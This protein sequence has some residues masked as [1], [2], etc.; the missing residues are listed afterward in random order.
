MPSSLGKETFFPLKAG[1]YLCLTVRTDQAFRR[2]KLVSEQGRLLWQRAYP[3]DTTRVSLPHHPQGWIS[4]RGD[5]GLRF[6]LIIIYTNGHQERIEPAY[7][8]KIG[9]VLPLA[10]DWLD[11][12]RIAEAAHLLESKGPSIFPGFSLAKVPFSLEGAAG[13]WVL[14]NHPNPPKGFVPYRGPLPQAP[15]P[16]KVYIGYGMTG[17]DSRGWSW[18]V[19]GVP[20]AALKFMPYWWVLERHASP[21]FDVVREPE[22]ND[23]IYVVLHEAFH[24]WW[25]K[26]FSSE[27]ET[28]GSVLQPPA[29][30]AIQKTEQECLSRAIQSAEETGQQWVKA[31]L[32][33]RERRRQAQGLTPAAKAREQLLEMG[34]GLSMYVG[35]KAM[36]AGQAQDYRPLN[37]LYADSEFRGYHIVSQE[38]SILGDQIR[39]GHDMHSSGRAMVQLLE[40][41]VVDWQL[42]VLAGKKAE[43]LLSESAQLVPLPEASQMQALYQAERAIINSLRSP[44]SLQRGDPFSPPA[45]ALKVWLEGL[46][47]DLWRSIQYAQ[48][49]MGKPVS[50]FHGNLPGLALEINA[51][52][53]AEVRPKQV[54]ILWEASRPLAV[55]QTKEGVWLQGE[56]LY[57]G[58]Q[59][60]I[61]WGTDGIHVRYHDDLW[62]LSSSQ[63]VQASKESAILFTSGVLRAWANRKPAKAGQIISIQGNLSG[64]FFNARTAQWERQ[65][66]SL[67]RSVSDLAF[68][69]DE[70]YDL[71]M[72][73]TPLLY[74]S[75]TYRIKMINRSNILKHKGI[76][77]LTPA[78]FRLPD[79]TYAVS[80]HI[81][82]RGSIGLWYRDSH[83]PLWQI[84]NDLTRSLPIIVL[85]AI[86]S[87]PISGATVIMLSRCNDKPIARNTGLEGQ[88]IFESLEPSIY[89]IMVSGHPQF[90]CFIKRRYDFRTV[91]E[92]DLDSKRY[93]YSVSRHYPIQGTI[94][95]NGTS[96]PDKVRVIAQ[97]KDGKI[98]Q[99]QV[100]LSPNPDGTYA[101]F[102][103]SDGAIAAGTWQ[104]IVSYQGSDTIQPRA[105]SVTVPSDCS[106]TAGIQLSPGS[107]RPVDVG[108]FHITID[109]PAK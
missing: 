58:G 61:T 9:K 23:R 78:R 7:S 28:S 21:G 106:P 15:F 77:S 56:G 43:D 57:L 24:A 34:E 60:Q 12:V 1:Y 104:V 49:Q 70:P 5:E 92:A 109:S 45:S 66:L 68:V 48:H 46:P 80:L 53:V 33:T 35:E 55:W 72:T 75:R 87:K 4:V 50:E 98:I 65:A 84:N 100:K 25:N 63:A 14:I 38:A 39:E 11:F 10:V 13:Q 27:S 42:K 96:N 89:D 93:R 47:I 101:F 6:R 40:R 8:A 59:V 37:A 95:I 30:W 103:P 36:L 18:G 102:I 85:D 31:F 69:S 91:R 41:Y 90:S 107:H 19:N 17:P 97:R 51:P 79:L 29:S 22:T 62:T 76:W 99:G 105:C 94:A 16:M 54:S 2:V 3:K 88:V 81:D 73:I 64:L 86:Q 71:K 74:K 26:R 108:Q 83:W 20:V 32:L 44:K 82:E 67:P 52:V